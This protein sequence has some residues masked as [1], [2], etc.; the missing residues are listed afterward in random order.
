MGDRAQQID[1]IDKH[2]YLFMRKK[3]YLDTICTLDLSFPC[4][5]FFIEINT[6]IFQCNKTY[7]ISLSFL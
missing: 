7:L 2:L 1:I 6:F 3:D 4:Y 5:I